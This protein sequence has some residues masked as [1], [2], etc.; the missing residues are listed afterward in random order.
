MQTKHE[1]G[2]QGLKHD[3]GQV[4]RK[5]NSSESQQAPPSIISL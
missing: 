5:I 2:V 3:N 1:S 4:L